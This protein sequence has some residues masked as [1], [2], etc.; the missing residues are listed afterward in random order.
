MSSLQ[1]AFRSWL[2]G[3]RE[4]FPVGTHFESGGALSIDG[5]FDMVAAL[6]GGRDSLDEWD[7]ALL[8][9]HAM[10]SLLAQNQVSK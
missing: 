6:T 1:I 7:F 5:A 2:E 8:Y 3:H 10:R 4:L 9:S